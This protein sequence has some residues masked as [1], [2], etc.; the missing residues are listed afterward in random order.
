[1]T[2]IASG[3]F[4]EVR[5]K[6]E[7]TEGTAADGAT[8]GQKLRRVVS[9]LDLSKDTYESREIRPSQQ[10]ADMRHGTRR[11][12]G[13]IDGELS[14]GGYPDLIEAM[15]RKDWT[16]GASATGLTIDAVVGP[17]GTF[18][19]SAGSW[20]TDGFRIGDVVR[21]T[22]FTVATDNNNRNYRIVDLTA[23][24]MTV[25]GKNNEVVQVASAEANITCTA[26][27]KKVLMPTGAHTDYSYTIEH[28]FGDILESEVFVGCK[29]TG[30][31]L[32]LPPTGIAQIGIGLMGHDIQTGSSAHFT[33]PAAAP[34]GANL[35]AVNGILR[36]GGSDVAVLTALSLSVTGGHTSDAVVGSNKVPAIVPGRLTVRG[37]FSALYEDGSL[38]DNF[39]N[40]EEIS[41]QLVMTAGNE[42][43]ADFMSFLLPRIKLG[44]SGKNDGERGLVQ[45][46]PFVA[47]ENEN[48]ATG[49]EATTIA[50]QDST[51]V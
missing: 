40:E 28:W 38:R 46:V 50:I 5:I 17:P 16:A 30:M 42:I 18:T 27:G 1:M 7:A 24:V 6:K 43:N 19:R 15:L 47:L 29:P 3:I 23:T 20:I 35:A 36:V 21:F 9:S 22:G 33:S 51:L 41:L 10:T 48:A 11:V 12:Q 13:R 39:I 34:T 49:E 8:G 44:G 32:N 45:T 4:K 2:K 14:P 25:S 31:N 37:Q 26:V